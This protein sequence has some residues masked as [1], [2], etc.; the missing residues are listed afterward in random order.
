MSEIV[1]E[2]DGDKNHGME[3]TYTL[4]P[5]DDVVYEPTPE[6]PAPLAVEPRP[7]TT[8]EID[9]FEICP[10]PSELALAVCRYIANL[11]LRLPVAPRVLE[12]SAG[13]GAFVAAVRAVW[14][15]SPVVAVECRPECETTLRTVGA[16]MVAIAR[17]EEWA[18]T[19]QGAAT[20]HSA[21]L[22]IGNPPFSHA[23]DHVRRLLSLMK[24]GAY[25]V[26]LLKMSF[27]ESFERLDFWSKHPEDGVAP[28]VPRPGFKLNGKGKKGTDSQAY[29]IF[30]WS[31]GAPAGDHAVLTMPRRLP[32]VVWR[33][34]V[35]KQKK[36]RKPRQPKKV[37]NDAPFTV[38]E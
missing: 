27:Y 34:S 30:L 1:N 11:G 38:L 20:I 12:P 22:V 25:L 36:P 7:P 3:P 28:I 37:V 21:D 23:E 17:F 33:E 31:A 26:F 18:E 35:A 24:P 6:A 32:H 19:A 14:S 29:C 13:E 9:T 4:E 10:T 15:H 5:V 2:P 8:A 16:D